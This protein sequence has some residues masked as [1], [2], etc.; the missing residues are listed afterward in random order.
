MQIQSIAQLR[1]QITSEESQLDALR[2][3]ATDMNPEVVRVRTEIDGLRGQLMK[4]QNGKS[5]AKVG[6]I[7]ASKVP[8]AGM[9]YIRKEREVKYHETLFQIIARQYES[10][11]MDEAHEAPLLQVV[12]SAVAP[13]SKAGPSRT[14][15]V[16]GGLFIGLLV[17]S[18][19]VLFRAAQRRTGEHSRV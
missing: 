12:D 16:L 19:G 14:L 9:E 15:I 2:Q 17:G 8:E 5:E 3:S 10:A 13:D 4:M 6:D 11:R 18:F 7:A 1:A